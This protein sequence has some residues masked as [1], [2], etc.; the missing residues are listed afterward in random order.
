LTVA[1]GLVSAAM[2]VLAGC[3]SAGADAE[4]AA[5]RF[6]QAIEAGEGS[7]ACTLLTPPTRSE[8]EQAE[9]APCEEALAKVGLPRVDRPIASERFGQQAQVR[10]GTDTVFLAEYD[11]GWKVLA[12]GCTRR[13]SLPYDC[14]VS[15][16]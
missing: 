15:G 10:F 6:Y 13:D 7:T 14:L 8:L 2:V 4:D 12:A 11:E 3:A 1:T 5:A 16:G 9:H